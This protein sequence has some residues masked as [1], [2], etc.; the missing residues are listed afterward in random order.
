MSDS[1][2]FVLQS[3]RLILGPIPKSKMKSSIVNEV[4]TAGEIV[5]RE[6]SNS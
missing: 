4:V 5:K 6:K 2:K 1:E 3:I